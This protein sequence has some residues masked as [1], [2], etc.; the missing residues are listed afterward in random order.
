MRLLVIGAS[1]HLGGEVARLA[2]AAGFEVVGTH[3]RPSRPHELHDWSRLDVRDPFA[4]HTLVQLVRPAAVIN[5]CYDRGSWS[6][7]ATGAAH[8]ATASAAVGARLVHISSD[9]LHAGRPEAYTEDDDPTPINAYGAAKAAAETAVAAIDPSAAMVRTS[10]IVGDESSH[11]TRFIL[12][13]V[14]RRAEGR[15]FTDEIRCPIDG[16]DLAAAV[17]ELVGNDYAGVLNVAGPEAVTRAELGRLIAV[18]HGHS[19]RSVPVGKAARSGM[20]RNLD[21][22]LDSSRAAGLLKTRLRP[23]SEVLSR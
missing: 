17:V 11:Q 15:L 16:S 4:V 9:A 22:K 6:A 3:A 19:R 23:I 5:A 21:V 7:M 2:P 8:V 1:G 18:R 10:L 12:D 14:N 13:L 20:V